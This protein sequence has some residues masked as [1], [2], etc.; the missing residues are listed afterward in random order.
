MLLLPCVCV[1]AARGSVLR[2]SLFAGAELSPEAAWRCDGVGA[3]G[4]AWRADGGALLTAGA[5][6]LKV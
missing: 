5:Q 3:A 1:R 6:Q 4:L 2:E